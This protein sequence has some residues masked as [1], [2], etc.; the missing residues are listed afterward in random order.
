[1]PRARRST[2]VRASRRATPTTVRARGDPG[3]LRPTAAG[4]RRGA[5]P[6]RLLAERFG[7]PA[8]VVP[9]PLD[10]FPAGPP[11]AA[12]G[13]RRAFSSPAPFEIDWKGVATALAAVGLLRRGASAASSSASRN[14]RWRGGAKAPRARRV[15]L[16]SA[17]A[18]VAALLRCCDLLLGPSWEQEGF[19]LPALEAMACGVP[20]VAS[21]V[22]CYRD[23]AAEAALLVPPS[24]RRPSPPPPARCWRRRAAGGGFGERAAAWRAASRP[25][26]RPTS[27]KRRRPGASRS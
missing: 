4:G 26:A 3:G 1:M 25:S 23:F 15:P 18:E 14:G 12:A 8:R 24:I 20:V 2:T 11:P 22:P 21:D 5:S 10:G 17:P 13:A 9:Q 16:P 27:P 19:G 7:R 6:G